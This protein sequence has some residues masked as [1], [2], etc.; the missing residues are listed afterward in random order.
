MAK[1]SE[2]E[3]GDSVVVK[4]GTEDNDL[5]IDLS[6]WQGRITEILADENI[7]TVEWDSISL[8]S[9]PDAAIEECEEEGLGWAEYRLYPE[10]VESAQPRDTKKD[11]ERVQE[12]LSKKFAWSFLGPEGRTINK[13]LAGVGRG[14]IMA[15]LGAWEEYLNEHLKFPFKAEVAEYQER[16]PLQASDRVQVLGIALI[17]D[18]YGVIVDVRAG[19]AK[20]AFPLADLEV[21]N[22]E[23][24][25][26]DVV[27]DYCVWFANRW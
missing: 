18:S 23:S 26:H 25:S 9:M 5:D 14:D 10:D 13:V 3:I 4:A 24:P 7:V 15:E 22:K 20:Y 16:G 17:D 11:V 12:A 21:L 2:L 27:H 6:G 19:R 1:L 8:Q